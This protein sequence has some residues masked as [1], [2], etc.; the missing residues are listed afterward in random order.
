ML[1]ARLGLGLVPPVMAAL[2]GLVRHLSCGVRP[3]GGLDTGQACRMVLGGHRGGLRGALERSAEASLP[4]RVLGPQMVVV[5]S[6]SPTA[7]C[8][9]PWDIRG[10]EESAPATD[11]SAESLYAQGAARRLASALS[12]GGVGRAAYSRWGLGPAPGAAPLPPPVQWFSAL[13]GQGTVSRNTSG[14]KEGLESDQLCRSGQDP[15][16]QAL[17]RAQEAGPDRPFSCPCPG[18]ELF[19]EALQKWEQALSV[20]QRG[21]DGSTPTPGDNLRNPETASE[22][23]SEVGG[24]PHTSC[25]GAT[26]EGWWRGTRAA[27]LSDM[28]PF[29]LGPQLPIPKAVIGFIKQFTVVLGTVPGTW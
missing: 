15:A 19:E 29:P 10:M 5:N 2:A 8:S 9:G 3:L 22:A 7:A 16:P 23:L 27:S 20:G 26:C 24:L 6:S 12:Q 21:D 17:G 1:R 18:M 4:D 25:P 13:F 14:P 11:G 28:T